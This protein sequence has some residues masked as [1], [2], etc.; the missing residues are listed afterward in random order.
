L[1]LRFAQL[2]WHFLLPFPRGL[3]R[4]SLSPR[5]VGELREEPVPD[6]AHSKYGLQD[7][8]ARHRPDT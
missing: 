3:I 4:S 1:S 2:S 8:R 5:A 6:Q 7:A